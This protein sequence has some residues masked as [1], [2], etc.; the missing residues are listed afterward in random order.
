MS[1]DMF[2][3]QAPPLCRLSLSVKWKD[4]KENAQ[5]TEVGSVFH[6]KLYAP[7]ILILIYFVSTHPAWTNMEGTSETY[8]SFMQ[9]LNSKPISFQM[10]WFLMIKEMKFS[11]SNNGQHWP[12]S[13]W[14]TLGYSIWMDGWMDGWTDVSLISL[15]QHNLLKIPLHSVP[16]TLD[17]SPHIKYF[18]KVVASFNVKIHHHPPLSLIR[19]WIRHRAFF[20]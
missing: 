3:T 1:N 18:L 12:S 13:C 9:I 17:I 4:H 2:P 14:L 19:I 20:P 11:S 7:G 16:A 15:L 8:D 5:D 6:M 10:N